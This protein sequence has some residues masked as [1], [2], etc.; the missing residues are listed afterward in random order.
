MALRRLLNGGPRAT[1][2]GDTIGSARTCDVSAMLFFGA[3]RRSVCPRLAALGGARPEDRAL[4]VGCGTG[5]PTR[6]VTDAVAPGGSVVGIDP[7]PT[8]IDAGR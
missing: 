6:L 3:W 1:T 5:Y 8:A 4:D 7:S 2:Q